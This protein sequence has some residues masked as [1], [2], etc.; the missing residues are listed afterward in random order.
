[1]LKN[2]QKVVE[3]LKEKGLTLSCAESCTGGLI[4]ANIT[5]VSGASEVFGLGV[6]S[7]AEVMKRKILKVP[8]K[9]LKNFGTIAP[10]TAYYMAKGV[11]RKA[12]SDIAISVTGVAGPTT[13]EGKP[14]GL[15]YIGLCAKNLAVVLELKADETL[16]RDE[17]RSKAVKTAFSLVLKYLNGELENSQN[18]KYLF[19]SK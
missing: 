7:Y 5:A 8:Q 17:I 2:A 1:M 4:A 9:I 3:K 15:V 18:Q 19:I 16:S 13:S 11:R 6:V 10:D 14:V 12:N